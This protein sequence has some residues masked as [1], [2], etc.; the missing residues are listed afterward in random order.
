[1]KQKRTKIKNRRYNKIMKMLNE[2]ESWPFFTQNRELSCGHFALLCSRL[3]LEKHINIWAYA[4]FSALP[5]WSV[6]QILADIWWRR[7]ALK[8]LKRCSV[9]VTNLSF[10]M[11]L[12]YTVCRDSTYFHSVWF[13]LNTR[14]SWF[15][16]GYRP[17][18]SLYTITAT[19]NVEFFLLHVILNKL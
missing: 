2:L 10:R 5:D 11:S 7:T 13:T 12:C 17:E 9:S 1:M 3:I 14:P 6:K 4:F 16:T 18:C 15:R 19:I 8:R